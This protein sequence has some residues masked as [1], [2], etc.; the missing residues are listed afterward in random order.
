MTTQQAFKQLLY[1]GELTKDKV[2]IRKWRERH[3]KNELSE[4][5]MQTLLLENG[6]KKQPEVWG[7]PLYSQV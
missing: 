1:S 7:K 2:L 6:Y 4:A 5:L 3:N